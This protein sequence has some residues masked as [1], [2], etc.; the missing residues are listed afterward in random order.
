[1]EENIQH[2]T[3]EKY[4]GRSEVETFAWAFVLLWAGFVFLA[5]NLGYLTR[6][7]SLLPA[8]PE[9]FRYLSA[10]PIVMIGAGVIFLISALLITI[11]P[12]K[13]HHLTGQFI[14]AAVA[15]GI[16][17]GQLYSWSLIGPFVLIAI[18]LSF[19]LRGLF[20]R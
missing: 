2:K 17:L 9:G 10:W 14:L 18:G 3:H 8:L 5:D 20:N 13:K 16:G 15:L 12:G 19:L 7:K 6:W 1:M 4:H 11:L